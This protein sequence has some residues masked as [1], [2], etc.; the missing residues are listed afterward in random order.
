MGLRRKT[1]IQILK[2]IYSNEINPIDENK[3]TDLLEK[4][5]LIEILL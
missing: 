1:R 4:K 3:W 5:I 2:D